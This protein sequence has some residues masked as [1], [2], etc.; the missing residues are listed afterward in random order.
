M[1]AYSIFVSIVALLLFAFNGSAQNLAYPET[2]GQQLQCNVMIEMPKGSIS[3]ICVLE[4]DSDTIR[5][6]IINEFGITALNFTYDTKADKVKLES[7]FAKL[8]KWYIRNV[9][10]KDIRELLMELKQGRTEYTDEKYKIKYTL[11]PLDGES[12]GDTPVDDGSDDVQ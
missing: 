9:L 11:S 1:R 4:N 8:D 2:N 3:G 7:V 10:E 6:A 5:G 12:E